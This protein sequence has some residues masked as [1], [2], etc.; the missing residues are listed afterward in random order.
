M[1]SLSSPPLHHFGVRCGRSLASGFSSAFARARRRNKP[2]TEARGEPVAAG[3]TSG[4]CWQ[5]S[6]DYCLQSYLVGRAKPPCTSVNTHRQHSCPYYNYIPTEIVNFLCEFLARRARVLYR[7]AHNNPPK[8][9]ICPNYRNSLSPCV[10]REQCALLLGWE[11]PRY[12]FPHAPKHDRY[13]DSTT[14]VLHVDVRL[15]ASH[16][17]VPQ[18]R[19]GVF[20]CQ[21]LYS[22]F[23]VQIYSVL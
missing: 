2:G 12:A 17:G 22:V 5:S 3:C 7:I 19:S 4:E 8:C 6:L 20:R 23:G 16:P 10:R 11:W 1:R 9:Y 21:K 14:V 18:G 13:G 15:F